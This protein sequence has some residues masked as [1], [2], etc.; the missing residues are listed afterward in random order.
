MAEDQRNNKHT[1]EKI[2]GTSM[3]RVEELMSSVLI[4]NLQGD[5]LYQRIFVVSAYAGVTDMLL[6]HKHSGDPGVYAL[7]N[8]GEDEGLWEEAL[9][10][11][12]AHM[13]KLNGSIFAGVEDLRNADRFIG[14]R[15]QEV[16]NSLRD[17]QSLCASGHFHLDAHLGVVRE[18]LAALGEVHSA[19]NTALLLQRRGVNG[20]FVDLSGWG[21]PESLPLEDYLL[22]KIGECDLSRELPI[23][24]GYAKC[25]EG[26]MKTYDRGYSEI[27]FSRLAALTK[28][29]EAVIHKEYHL[30][31]ADPKI[32]GPNKAM[33][34]GR[35]NY[36]VADQ[37]SILG[38]EAIH[39]GAAQSLRRAAI[40]LRV[41][42]SFEPDHEGTVIEANYRSAEPRVEIIAGRRGVYAVEFF[43]HDIVDRAGHAFGIQKILDRYKLR[44][45][46]RESNANC[47]TYYLATNLKIVKR[48]E[49][50]LAAEFPNAVV[51]VRRVGI[52][53]AV[54]SNLDVSGLLS[55]CVSALAEANINLL[56]VHQSM[57]AVDIKFV[58][59]E[60]DVQAAT[61][62][63][64]ERAVEGI[65]HSGQRVKVA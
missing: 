29:R 37:L 42:H 16:R 47:I 27:T 12:L 45:V 20:R 25:A 54:G 65:S 40:P 36:D 28:A 15:V 24:T 48:I 59:D 23:C 11:T 38:M 58:V 22:R 44:T 51:T 30:C 3:S 41:R 5:E 10:K 52:V 9:A 21:E 61:I 7:F 57:R 64:H 32:V 49:R 63:L 56:A 50:D 60:T 46:T 4:G 26:L 14:E 18:M 53:A 13:H 33:P 17:L 6:E 35:T 1:V 39:P 62:A 2:G 8:E 34:I 55:I 43:S 19:Y 31:S